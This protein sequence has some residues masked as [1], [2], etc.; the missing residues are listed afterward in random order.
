MI[1]KVTVKAGARQ[2][3]VSY[4]ESTDTYVVT[5]KARPIEGEA[6]K[7]IISLLANDLGI[8]KTSLRL[9]SGSKSKIKRFE[10]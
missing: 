9:K 8:A 7:A 5:V 3:S 2:D 1:I 4:D 10:Y 6:N